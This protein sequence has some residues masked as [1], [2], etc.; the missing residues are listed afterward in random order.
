MKKVIL[1]VLAFVLLLTA[2]FVKADNNKISISSFTLLEKSENVVSTIEGIDGLDIT[3]DI[4]FNELNDYVKYELVLKNDSDV[5]YTIANVNDDNQNGHITTSYEVS[6]NEFKSGEEISVYVTMKYTSLIGTTREDVANGLSISLN[7]DNG[8]ESTVNVV[9]PEVNPSTSD[10]VIRYF[11]TLGVS[12]IALIFV[13][14]GVKKYK[15]FKALVIVAIMVPTFGSAIAARINFKITGNIVINRVFHDYTVTYMVDGSQ[16][17]ADTVQE[18]QFAEEL[19]APVKPGYKFNYWTVSGSEYDFTTPISGDVTLTASYS[20]IDYSI[21]YNL[22]GGVANNNTSYTVEDEFTLTAPQKAGY[23]FVGWTGSNGTEPEMEVT[24]IEGTTGNLNYTANYQVITYNITYDLNQG[25]A[26]NPTTYTVEDEIVLVQPTR[27]R[28]TFDGWTGSNGTEPQIE[29]T[30][31]KGTTGDLTYTANFSKQKFDITIRAG[32]GIEKVALDGWTNSGT[33][34]MTKALEDESTLDLTTITITYK[35]GYSGFAYDTTNAGIVNHVLTVANENIITLKATELAAPTCGISGG[36]TKVYNYE[37]SSLTAANT[38][39]YDDGVELTYQFGYSLTP[40]GSLGN[41]NEASSENTL[42]ILKDSYKGTRY[43]G[44]KIEANGDGGLTANCT[45]DKADYTT[46]ALVNAQIFFDATTNGGTIEGSTTR[47]VPYGIAATYSGRENSTTGQIPIAEKSGYEF[48]G[49]Y[50]EIE[51]GTRVITSS[52]AV[53]TSKEGWTNENRQWLRT[54]PSIDEETIAERTLYAQF[55][56]IDYTLI[57]DAQ[58]GIISELEGW[59]IEA[60]SHRAS[61]IVTFDQ[62]IGEMPTPE[63]GA[64]IFAGWNTKADGTGEF[65]T[66]ESTY[67]NPAGRTLYAIWVDSEEFTVTYNLDG[68]DANNPTELTIYDTVTLTNPTK[69]GYTFIGWTGSNGTTPEMEVTIDKNVS[70]NLVF[71]ANYEAIEYPITYDLDGGEANNPDTYTIEDEIE[72]NN[73]IK[74]GF[75]FAG[76]TGSNSNTPE[77]NVTILE[78]TTGPLSYVAH[79]E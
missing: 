76:W 14:S 27:L 9:D 58:D 25:Y 32:A 51:E 15:V 42:A 56:P 72:L 16:Y 57:L 17:V 65:I 61:K 21:T 79:Y 53:L 71:T 24:I 33:S 49:W 77:L 45:T 59:E 29:V 1:T 22:D 47:Y 8:E 34:E 60:G 6:Q 18:E 48:L 36:T 55:K 37:D 2:T 11:V 40:T 30:I 10:N 13:F 68:G 28:Y 54:D 78:G 23:N 74:D 44:V 4:S 69:E 19:E 26:A 64:L 3:A 73:P 43:F 75:T 50:T 52:R 66:S 20:L 12:T 31:P 39:V 41:F 63:K 35:D 70:G 7:Y 38:T 5:D 46:N 67:T 62:A